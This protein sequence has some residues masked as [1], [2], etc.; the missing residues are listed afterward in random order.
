MRPGSTKDEGGR[1]REGSKRGGK[2]NTERDETVVIS[3]FLF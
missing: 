1:E 3:L 2:A